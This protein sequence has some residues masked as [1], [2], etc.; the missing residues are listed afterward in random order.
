MFRTVLET[1]SSQQPNKKKYFL[2]FHKKAIHKQCRSDVYWQYTW[3]GC[4]SL[5]RVNGMG[6]AQIKE[7][8]YLQF[9]KSKITS[10][11]QQLSELRLAVD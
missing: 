8:Q 2:L 6:V 10:M 11:E 1:P 9:G 4:M 3:T 7:Q 5:Q